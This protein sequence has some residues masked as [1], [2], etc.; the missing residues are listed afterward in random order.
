MKLRERLRCTF[1]IF[2]LAS[3][4]ISRQLREDSLLST[5]WE[6]IFD[7]AVLGIGSSGLP[8]LCLSYSNSKVYI[9]NY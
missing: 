4:G 7:N 9:K 5:E 1:G 8:I 2:L 6:I 3:P